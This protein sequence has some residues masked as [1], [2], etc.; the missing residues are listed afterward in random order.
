MIHC[1][2]ARNPRL[3]VPATILPVVIV[4]FVHIILCLSQ[5]NVSEVVASGLQHTRS[6]ELDQLEPVPSRIRG[7][8]PLSTNEKS[9]AAGASNNTVSGNMFSGNSLFTG[10]SYYHVGGDAHISSLSQV[11]FGAP[12]SRF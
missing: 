9:E 8:N 5:P 4:T 12:D 2:Q 6:C 10:G 7:N 3:S 11:S 1:Q